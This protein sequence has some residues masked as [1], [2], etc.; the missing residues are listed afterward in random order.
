[1]NLSAFLFSLALTGPTVGAA[2]AEAGPSSTATTVTSVR[3]EVDHSALLA[4][5]MADAAE[6]S[7]FFVR[8]DSSKAL[9]EQHGVSVVEGGEAPTIIVELAWKDYEGSVYLIEIATRRAGEPPQVV[10]SF[11]ATCINN[12]ALTKAVVAKLPA[13]LEQLSRP[14]QTDAPHSIEDDPVADPVVETEPVDE[15]RDRVPLGPK[16]K[17]GIGLLAAGAVG[18]ITGGIVFAQDRRFDEEPTALD[19][20][21][22]DYRPPG[23]GVMVAGGVVAVTGAV[24]LII[25]RS[26]AKRARKP[27]KP[28]AWL[29]PTPAGLAVTGRF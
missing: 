6:D 29:V 18:V 14:Q 25:D 23:V 12:T 8:D 20:Q 5:Q 3:L 26:Q 11:E 15:H 13:A 17:T 19:W 7:A 16:G 27:A 9:R 21:G 10:E 24:L 28:T 22:K 1:M 2:N 4:Q